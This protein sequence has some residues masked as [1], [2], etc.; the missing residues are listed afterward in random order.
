MKKILNI[1]LVNLVIFFVLVL[2]HE[3]S[4]AI[5]GYYFGCKQVKVVLLD[6]IEGPYTELTCP[7]KSM[8]WIIYMSGLIATTLFSFP[9]LFLKSPSNNLF[10][11]V[12]GFSIIFSAFDLSI[13]FNM[14]LLFYIAIVSGFGF[15]SV[16][17][18]FIALNC[19]KTSSLTNL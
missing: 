10:F 8:N 14:E 18:Y 9:F 4:H 5:T 15:M 1:I 16:G 13:L 7:I 17:E 19:V 11:S 3:A 6:V 2:I 12:L